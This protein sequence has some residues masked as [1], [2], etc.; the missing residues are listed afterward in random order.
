MFKGT[1]QRIPRGVRFL[2][3]LG[4]IVLGD[5][6]LWPKYSW[7]RNIDPDDVVAAV[8]P[9]ELYE[10][11]RERNPRLL[12]RLV[13]ALNGARSWPRYRI[14]WAEET[15]LHF[16]RGPSLA[17][18][19]GE[20]KDGSEIYFWGQ[21]RNN[22]SRELKF[23]RA[24]GLRKVLEEVRASERCRM[25]A[26]R[27]PPQ[28]LNRVVCYADGSQQAFSGSDVRARRMLAAVNEFLSLTNTSYYDALGNHAGRLLY[29][30]Q[31][32]PDTYLKNT[33]GAVLV[34]DPPV[35]MHTTVELS[36][37]P[38]IAEYHEFR[39]SRLFLSDSISWYGMKAVG[40]SSDQKPSRFYLFF[41]RTPPRSPDT[42][43]ATKKWQNI[44]ASIQG[45]VGEPRTDSQS[46]L[47]PSR[48]PGSRESRFQPL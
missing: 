9:N 36:S 18:Y 41:G 26:P 39:T 37:S 22:R 20:L 27:I 46:R 8:L 29:E 17:F 14:K 10:V 35:A 47:A 28:S 16:R 25:R 32:Q 30:G 40:F 34:L 21:S 42:E 13:R 15:I 31:A 12:K 45:A 5:R 3:I 19:Y 2:L 6:L 38:T 23:Y 44:L 24:G 1:F 48:T 7:E 33:T 11:H 4:I 43:L